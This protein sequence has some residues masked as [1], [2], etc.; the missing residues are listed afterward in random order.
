MLDRKPGE[1]HTLHGGPKGFGKRLWKL[2][3]SDGSSVSMTLE[4]PDGEAGFPGALTATCVYQMLEPATLRVELS[5][6]TDKPTVVNLTQHAY[7]NLDGS[8]TFSTMK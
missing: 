5:A 7:F 1:K 6:V 4:S 2:G 3:A 8:R